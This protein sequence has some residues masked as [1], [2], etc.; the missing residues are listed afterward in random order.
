VEAVERVL[1]PP[2]AGDAVGFELEEI[3]LIDVLEATAGRRVAAPPAP[4][5]LLSSWAS[6]EDF[7]MLTPMTNRAVA[8]TTNGTSS[9]RGCIGR[10]CRLGYPSATATPR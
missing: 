5:A 2:D 10:P 1:D 3:D 4:A 7:S 6:P 8:A 9:T